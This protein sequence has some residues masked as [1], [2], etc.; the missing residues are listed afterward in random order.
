MGLGAGWVRACGGAGGLGH[1]FGPQNGSVS[2]DMGVR[3]RGS[4]ENAT[5]PTF[6]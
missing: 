6:L 5:R 2:E 4:V 3:E 1:C